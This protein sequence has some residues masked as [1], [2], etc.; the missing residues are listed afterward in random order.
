[1]V[2]KRVSVNELLL[3]DMI[4][5]EVSEERMKE[6][7]D[8]FKNEITSSENDVANDESEVKDTDT[9]KENIK[10]NK[11][12]KERGGYEELY[13]GY[14]PVDKFN[15]QQIYIDGELYEKF[16]RFLKVVGDRKMSMTSFVNNILSQHWEDN[17]N[18]M[19]ELYDKNMNK[20]L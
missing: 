9:G 8:K 12:K 4:A 1:M 19:S 10:T 13:L 5:G 20:P 16:A 15:R 6:E 11:R 14:R 7:K 2:R 18:T 17:K 3:Q